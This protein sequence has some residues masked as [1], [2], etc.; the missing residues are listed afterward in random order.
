MDI[1]TLLKRH[2]DADE[3]QEWDALT[4]A[5][6]NAEQQLLDAKAQAS[7]K[8]L[9]RLEDNLYALQRRFQKLRMRAFKRKERGSKPTNYFGQRSSISA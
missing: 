3:R 4:Q 5:I 6:A 1:S 9:A 8:K 2:L 7:A